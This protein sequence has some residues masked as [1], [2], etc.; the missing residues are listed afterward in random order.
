MTIIKMMIGGGLIAIKV[1]NGF[2]VGHNLNANCMYMN[3]N[4]KRDN[5]IQMIR[6]HNIDGM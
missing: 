1:M 5:N 2:A 3:Y 6:R 4:G